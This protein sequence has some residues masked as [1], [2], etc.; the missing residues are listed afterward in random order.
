ML[1]GGMNG[2]QESIW[3]VQ[4][5]RYTLSKGQVK[6][7]RNPNRR[8]KDWHEENKQ[9]VW[10]RRGGQARINTRLRVEW[11]TGETIQGT[12]DGLRYVRKKSRKQTEVKQ[13]WDM[14]INTLRV[15]TERVKHNTTIPDHLTISISERGLIQL[16]CLFTVFSLMQD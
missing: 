11:D 12:A 8:T 16:C 3:L 1:S 9:S 13:T 2:K 14:K 7:N 4:K 15:M 6:H 5:P 10:Q